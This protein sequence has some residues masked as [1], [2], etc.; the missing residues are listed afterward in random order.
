LDQIYETMRRLEEEDGKKI[1][2][3]ISCGDFQA[4]RNL[5]DMETMAC[6][7]KYRQMGT[8][9]KYYSGE[10]VAPYPTLFI[11][12]N[13]EATN[14]L[15]ELYFGGFAAPNIYFLGYAGCIQ[16]GGIRI[17]GLSG[18][19]NARHFDMGHFEQPPYDSST[20]RSAYH[21]RSLEVNRLLRLSPSIDIFLSHDWPTGIAKFG[22]VNALLRR[23]AFLRSEIED[24]SLGSPV[25]AHLLSALRPKHWFS[26]HL[27]TKFS[28]LVHH[29]E[30]ESTRFL[31]LDK[32]LPGRQFLQ[33][34]EFPYASQ[35]PKEFCYDPEWLG[36]LRETHNLL[37]LSR[38]P[39]PLPQPFAVKQETLSKVKS[40]L[41]ARG[42]TRIPANFEMTAPPHFGGTRGRGRMPTM[43]LRNP[44]TLDFLNML[45]LPYNLSSDPVNQQQNIGS[46]KRP[47]Q[48]APPNPEEVVVERS[49]VPVM[50]NPE[51]IDLGDPDL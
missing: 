46:N 37:S 38:H 28:A 40:I 6:P 9:Y 16:F 15:W 8:F 1:D 49:K 26:A 7:P 18:I 27:H 44:Q 21:V 32:C 4:M 48:D 30:G 42:G 34:V 14:Y 36:V 35:C 3:L 5:D 20:M 23:K 39:A 24:G 11:G 17:A 29:A 19:Y 41:D 22:D 25:S 12:G 51:E 43:I 13:H 10:K 2:L 45:E 33:V 50:T 31:S 47:R